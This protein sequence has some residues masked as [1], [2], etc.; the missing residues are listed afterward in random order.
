MLI[1]DDSIP[2]QIGADPSS[3][4]SVHWKGRWLDLARMVW[5]VVA[6]LSI[7]LYL[8]SLPLFYATTITFTSPHLLNPD[9]VR[10]GLEQLG[11]SIQVFAIVNLAASTLS[12][13]AFVGIGIV[14]FWKKGNERAP[15]FFSLVLIT[16]GVTWPN[17]LPILV[18]V[19]PLFTLPVNFID[20]IGFGTFFWLCYTFPDGHFVPRWT[21]PIAILFLILVALIDLFPGTP[22]DLNTWPPVIMLIASLGFIG[23]MLFAPVYRYRRASTPTQ[24]QQIKWV[25]FSLGIAIASLLGTSLIGNLP[26]LQ[27]PGIPAALYFLARNA[28]LYFSFLLIPIAIG[29]AILR[30]RL[31]DI[32]PIINRTLIYAILTALVVGGYIAIIAGLG[33]LFR[34]QSNLLLS[35]VATGIIAV[36]FQPLRERVQRSVNRLIYGE[37]DDPFQVLRRLGKELESV[38]QPVAT[39][40]LTVETIAHALKLSYVTIGLK[41]DDRIQTVASYGIAHGEVIRF[42]LHYGGD[43]IGELSVAP[44]TLNDP[45]TL[46]D[47]RFLNE[48]STHISMAAHAALLSA[49][50]ERSRLSIVA[51]RE[52]SRRCL[53][54]DLHDGVGHQLTGMARQ[55]EKAVHLL[56]HEPAAVQVV[57]AEIS[58]QVNNTMA[59]VRGLAHQLHP[60]EL[61]LLGLVGALREQAQTHTSFMIQIDAP[62]TIPPLPTEVETAAY[63]I[64]LEALSNVEKHAAAKSFHLH[65]TLTSSDSALQP[66]VLE[67]EINDDGIGLPV[68]RVGGLGLLSMQ[69]RAIELG[70]TCQIEPAPT[71]G[72]RIRVRLPCHPELKRI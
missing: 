34:L 8:A 16:F 47:R 5:F 35:L 12:V 26:S 69:G 3:D 52:E 32:D 51:A 25:F 17:T 66:S 7:F 64:A 56:E 38:V 48:L 23:T 68:D 50:L 19:N 65:L 55:V 37:R 4:D 28:I 45:L 14:I 13:L 30:Y 10:A 33:A 21:R 40:P 67:M 70:G 62:E 43:E 60:P 58:Q 9:A 1:T 72:T 24:R 57:L 59:R 54:N 44:R 20:I 49:E 27:Q 11:L 53:G 61:E 41:Q 18:E 39:L 42:P 22:L 46:A 29:A 2:Q 71:G 63:Y 36:I 31:W 15:W 6:L